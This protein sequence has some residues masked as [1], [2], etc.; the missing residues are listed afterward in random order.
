[1]GARKQW[2]AVKFPTGVTA[3][4]GEDGRVAG[5]LQAV[6]E[7]LGRR[8]PKQENEPNAFEVFLK[9]YSQTEAR[10]DVS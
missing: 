8:D 9:T 6:I 4:I 3:W 7:K 10:H 5:Y 1:M 2:K